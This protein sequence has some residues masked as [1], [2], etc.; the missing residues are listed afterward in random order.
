MAVSSV[1]IGTTT[2]LLYLKQLHFIHMNYCPSAAIGSLEYEINA[3]GTRLKNIRTNSCCLELNIGHGN[4]GQIH[5]SC[6]YS[7]TSNQYSII[8]SLMINDLYSV[9][10][11]FEVLPENKSPPWPPTPKHKPEPPFPVPRYYS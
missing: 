6:S 10:D 8:F 5:S 11:H 3:S 9:N 1:T 7:S 2:V 4:S